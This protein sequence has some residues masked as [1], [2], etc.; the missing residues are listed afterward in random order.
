MYV[1]DARWREWPEGH[2][3]VPQ[4]FVVA[5][6]EVRQGE[7][8]PGGDL[9]TT[10]ALGPAKT[11]LKQILKKFK[12]VPQFQKRAYKSTRRDNNTKGQSL[13]EKAGAQTD[14]S[15]VPGHSGKFQ[16]YR[17]AG[18]WIKPSKLF[19]KISEGPKKICFL[20]WLK[21]FSFLCKLHFQTNKQMQF[22]Q[23]RFVHP[24][25]LQICSQPFNMYLISI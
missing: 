23:A 25:H 14:F 10:Q 3:E 22:L 15:Y 20:F 8:Q 24:S 6:A 13:L 1:Q 9:G 21:S 12:I 16:G 17:C 19:L 2:Y 4:V 5:A 7:G 18:K 11:E